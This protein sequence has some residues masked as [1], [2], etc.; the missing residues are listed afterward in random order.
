MNIQRVAAIM[1]VVMLVL[2]LTLILAGTMIIVDFTTP[3][4]GCIEPGRVYSAIVTEVGQVARVCGIGQVA[5]GDILVEIE[6]GALS[7]QWSVLTGAIEKLEEEL[8]REKPPLGNPRRRFELE[9]QMAVKQQSAM[10]LEEK[11]ARMAIRAPFAG[12][13]V[14]SELNVGEWAL[15]GAEPVVVLVDES[16]WAFRGRVSPEK[17]RDID[18]GTR[19]RVRVQA[20]PY[21]THGSIEGKVTG[22]EYAEN[23]AG[24]P[25]YEVTVRLDGEPDFAL[26]MG[27]RATSL[28]SGFKG[29]VFQYMMRNEVR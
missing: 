27:Q 8:D 25:V 14:A 20:Y 28:I 2:V 12:R 9:Q 15:A 10:G 16:S 21:R 23:K 26:C 5:E 22:V 6:N 11:I 17:M 19:A 4:D 7:E 18:N 29:S 3:V 13:V 1:T 24:A